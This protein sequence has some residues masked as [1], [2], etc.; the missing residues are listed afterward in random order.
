VSSKNLP[1]RAA[2]TI[3]IYLDLIGEDTC[4]EL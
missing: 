1:W 2:L 3:S 4:H